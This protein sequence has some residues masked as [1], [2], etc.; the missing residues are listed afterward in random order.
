MEELLA[1]K[2]RE[3]HKPLLL[4][5]ARQVGKTWIL[6]QF[7]RE[8]YDSY[9]Y[10]NF[11]KEPSLGSV[12]EENKDPKRILSLLSMLAGK[13]IIPE[14]TLVILDEIQLC[15]A[16]LNTV[17]YFKEETPE[18][19]IAVAG[20]LLGVALGEQ[21]IPVG[22][23]DIIHMYPMTFPEFL[24][25]HNRTLHDYYFS[26]GKDTRIEEVFHEKLVGEYLLYML[27]GGMPECVASYLEFNDVDEVERIQR[28]LIELYENDFTKY[29]G[30]IDAARILQVF[31]S[32]VPQLSKPNE[33]FVYGAIRKGARSVQFETAIEWLVSAGLIYRVHNV[34]NPGYPLC[35]YEE[36]DA[37]KIFFFDTGLLRNMAGIHSSSILMKDPFQFKRPMT[38]N[39]VLQQLIPILNIEPFY[40]STNTDEIDFLLQLGDS[41]VPV[42]VKCGTDKEAP[43]FK[44][45]IK[46][47]NPEIAIRF[48]LRNYKKDGAII[49]MPLYLAPRLLELL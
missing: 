25:E 2:K 23:A 33:K 9:L 13:S 7:A 34:N 6:K 29:A 44:K 19:H 37:F 21:Q 11:E 18:Y 46:K 38:E 39:Y 15:P 40:Y 28:D 14:K 32:I 41:I 26:I 47:Y 12:F 43:S 8:H 5:G 3:K 36:K 17:K 1:W 30:R 4:K 24:Y 45:Y 49:N 27:I 35:G 10:F 48:S 20:S 42:E 22:M 16:A 31:R